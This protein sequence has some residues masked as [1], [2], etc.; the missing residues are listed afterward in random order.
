MIRLFLLLAVFL[1]SPKHIFAQVDSLG[2]AI[3]I[4]I[5]EAVQAGDIVCSEEGG[6]ALC[7]EEYD[8][9][10]YGVIVENPPVSF[11]SP[12]F[13]GPLLVSSGEA[14]VRVKLS[15]GPIQVGDIVTTSATPGVG[16]KATLNGFVLGTAME[17]YS[18]SDPEAIGKVLVSINIHPNSSFVGAR[19]NL[20]S[21][22][23]QAL[24]AP[25]VSPLDSLR[26]LLAFLVA[27]I[28]FALGFV[29]F[30]RVVKSGVEAIGRNPLASRTIQITILINIVI[31]I[32]IVLTGL[33]LALLILII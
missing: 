27:L 4:V 29:Y 25:V 10:I 3:P 14:L 22:F 26:Y 17:D 19:S 28:S 11:E 30:G 2:V 9:A 1:V 18:S 23:R 5:R 8:P 32:V 24:S 7:S 31:T 12:D 13:T 21:N 20:I 16:Q 6:H 33:G 15:N